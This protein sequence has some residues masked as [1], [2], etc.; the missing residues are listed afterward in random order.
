MELRCDFCKEVDLDTYDE[1]FMIMKYYKKSVDIKTVAHDI[2]VDEKE[3]EALCK[4][5]KISDFNSVIAYEDNDL[6]EKNASGS[7]IVKYIGKLEQFSEE[8][9]SDD[10]E[11]HYLWIGEN[12]IDKRNIRNKP[13]L[14]KTKL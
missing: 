13:K 5:H 7:T 8:N 3:L 12:K 9:L 2:L 10:S 14:I 1:D 6:R 11:V 4:K